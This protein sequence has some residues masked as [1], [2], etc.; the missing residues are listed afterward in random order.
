M[1]L[2]P[3]TPPVILPYTFC[4]TAETFCPI[5]AFSTLIT[6]QSFFKPPHLS[7][8]DTHS[9]MNSNTA[10]LVLQ[11]TEFRIHGKIKKYFYDF[12]WARSEVRELFACFMKR[13]SCKR[14]KLC[15][16]LSFLHVFQLSSS[17][18]TIWNCSFIFNENIKRVEVT[19]CIVWLSGHTVCLQVVLGILFKGSL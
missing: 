6:A 18:R 5:V 13:L 4:P 7:L 1:I 3:N 15:Q 8:L 12:I 11:Q 9:S 10:C 16:S 14:G 19:I 17:K 2:S